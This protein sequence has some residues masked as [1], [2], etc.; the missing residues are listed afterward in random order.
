MNCGELGLPGDMAREK[1]P[2]M[3]NGPLLSGQ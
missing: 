3:Q 1:F 2:E